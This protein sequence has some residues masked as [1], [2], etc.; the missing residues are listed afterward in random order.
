MKRFSLFFVTLALLAT[1][2]PAA[3]AGHPARETVSF[4]V[5]SD[6][7][8]GSSIFVVGNHPDLG[9]WD[10]FRAIKLRWTAGNVWTGQAAIQAGTAIEY[11]FITRSL[12]APLYYTNSNVTW[13]PGDN[14]TTNT[15]AGP[16]APFTGKTVYYY[17]GWTSANIL[18]VAPGFPSYP[19]ERV[20]PGRTTNE[21]L[22]RVTGIGEEGEWLEFVPNGYAGGQQFWDNPPWP[23]TNQNYITRLDAFVVQDGGIYNYWPAP[24]VS[25]MRKEKRSIGSSYA[26]PIDGRDVDIILPRGY[27]SHPWKR[28]PVVYFQDGQNITNGGN[29]FNNGSWEADLTA[30]RESSAG[31]MREAILVGVYN[32][33]DRRRWEYNPLGDTY[34]SNSPGQADAYLNFLIHNVRP[35]IDT[36]YRTLADRRNTFVAGSSMGGIF[37]IYAGFESNVFGGVLAMS[38]SFT[39]AGNYTTSLWSRAKAPIRLYLD[40]GNA[41]GQVGDPPG[42]N[43]WDSPWEGYD[44]FIKQGFAPNRDFLMRIGNNHGHNEAAWR[45][46]L[47]GAFNFLLPASD[48]PN[49]VLLDHLPP[50]I[51]AIPAPHQITVSTQQHVQYRVEES[52]DEAGWQVASPAFIE[53]NSWDQRTLSVTSA[54]ATLKTFRIR[55]TPND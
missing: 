45:A 12:S 28:Y 42:G 31:R 51:G 33:P 7:G 47:P 6:A 18:V 19:M 32:Y 22:Y 8:F 50:E 34:P 9:G 52:T 43:Y 54:P 16:A 24:T 17:S 20:G 11:K 38:P 40:T 23:E 30:L 48:D 29:I 49:R 1:G 14:R 2:Q 26:P 13:E 37:S 36:H 15:V 39:R 55:A 5:V 21:F 3:W 44:I 4:S 41:E 46:R 10:P 25:A 53:T 27:D 35:T